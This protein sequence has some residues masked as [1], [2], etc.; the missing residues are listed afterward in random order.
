LHRHAK[1]ITA[2]SK[3]RAREIGTISMRLVSEHLGRN[4]TIAEVE[5]VDHPPQASREGGENLEVLFPFAPPVLN[6]FHPHRPPANP[7]QS[8]KNIRY[9]NHI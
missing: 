8:L 4:H 9:G 2:W 1:I 6:S 5:H 7:I 3:K